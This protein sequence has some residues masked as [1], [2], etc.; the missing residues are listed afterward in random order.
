VSPARRLASSFGKDVSES[1]D[2]LG[3]PLAFCAF[4]R[5][6]K[7]GWS[8]LAELRYQLIEV[9][10]RRLRKVSA[11]VDGGDILGMA[12]GRS[13]FIGSIL[14]FYILG[15]LA[16]SFLRDDSREF[17]PELIK[18]IVGAAVAVNILTVE[19]WHLLD[20]IIIVDPKPDAHIL[21]LLS[22]AVPG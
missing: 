18:G 11:I 8:A 17:V 15:E 16:D 9:G 22:M 21:E 1:R 4:L 19:P 3:E 2:A 13:P 6:S 5:R 12:T 10:R 20:G 7:L 14:A